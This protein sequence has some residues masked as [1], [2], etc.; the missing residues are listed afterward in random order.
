MSK[1]VSIIVPIYKVES[2]LHKCI[3]SIIN[4]TYKNLEIILVDDGSPDNC[5]KICDEFAIKD[6]RIKVIHKQNGGL[7][8]ARNAGLNIAT[9][10]YLY[11]VDSDDWISP[12][13]IEVL[14]SYFESNPDVDIVAGSS[15]DVHEYNGEILETSYSI[16]LGTISQLNKIEALKHNLQNG[17]AAW[18][19]L[20][21]KELFKDIRFPKGKINEDEAV[22]LFILSLCE[23]IILVG[24]PTYYYFLRPES[25]TTSSFSEK[26]M[27][28]FENCLNNRNFIENHYPSLLKEAE[29]RIITCI[30]YLLQF[31]L[32]EYKRFDNCISQLKTYIFENYRTIKT[33]PYNTKNDKI[34]ILLFKV[35]LKYNLKSVY[36]FLYGIYIKLK[37]VD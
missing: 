11:F 33:N 13:A 3:D 29:Y 7:S 24:Q 17:W 28:W 20:Y 14:I 30:L 37:R 10:D 32:I 18:N 27:H 6:T 16:P 34:K 2:Y 35:I 23:K 25:I 21:K 1:L 22:M 26:K 15:V 12:D 9:G 19:K 5:G 36:S 31:M 4:Q 8:D